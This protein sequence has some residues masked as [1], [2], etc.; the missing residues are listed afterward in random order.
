MKRI[1]LPALLLLIAGGP[2]MADLYQW[3]DESGVIHITD[4]EEKVPQKFR[5]QVKVF[6][7]GPKQAEPTEEFVA[8]EEALPEID[9]ELDGPAMAVEEEYGGETLEW[10]TESFKEKRSEIS[11]LQATIETKADF[12]R[13]FEG[14]RRFGQIYDRESVDRYKAYQKELPEDREKLDKL[15]EDLK[16]FEERARRARVPEEIRK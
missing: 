3:K 8:P 9:P 2:A 4:S 16:E 10:W 11:D 13:V 1:V 15:L 14:G 12:M 6:K 7:E 5:D